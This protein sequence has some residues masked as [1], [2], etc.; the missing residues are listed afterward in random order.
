M[1]IALSTPNEQP[2]KAKEYQK[3]EA[4][5]EIGQETVTIAAR[6][7]KSS[8]KASIGTLDQIC[9]MLSMRA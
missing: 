2:N 8:V 1:V 6:V 5:D 3:E 9:I 7:Y 4:K